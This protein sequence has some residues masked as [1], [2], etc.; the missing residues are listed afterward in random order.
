[1]RVDVWS[2]VACPWCYVGLANLDAALATFEHGDEVDVVLHSYQLDPR[3]PLRDDTPVAERIA[4][5]Y[6]RTPEQ[7]EAGH[8]RL[9]DMGSQVGIDFRFDD[10]IRSNTLDAHRLLHLAADRGTQ[11]ALKERLLRA[12]F[13]DGEV[14]GDHDVLRKVAADVGL[15]PAEVDDVL[16]GDRYADDVAA[17]IAEAQDIGVTGVPFFVF[18]GRLGLP[19]AQPPHTLLRVLE[20]AWPERVTGRVAIADET[21]DADACGPDG[22]EI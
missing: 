20:R 13:T 10:V 22:C 12:Y 21:A 5:K 4:K 11:R 9:R 7:V 3:A 17:D 16:A 15:D 8:D 1:M 18:D 19:G 14:I 2:D 6:G